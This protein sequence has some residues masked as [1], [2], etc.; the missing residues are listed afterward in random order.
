LKEPQFSRT[1]GGLFQLETELWLPRCREQVFP[2]FADAF[3]LET[4]TPPWLH[5][6]VLTP[7]PIQ[8]RAGLR[9]NY[10][11][12]LHGCPLRWQSEITAWDPPRRF[13]DEQRRGP[14]RAWIHE[15]LFEQRNGG[16]LAKDLVRYDVL[17]GWLIN[18]LFV[19]SDVERIFRFRQARLQEVFP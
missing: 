10:R 6:E 9:I 12:K 18:R 17:G 11:L 16:T 8:M 4:L 2:F 7:R 15:H 3:N 5:F 13:V 1:V 14:Y 19:R